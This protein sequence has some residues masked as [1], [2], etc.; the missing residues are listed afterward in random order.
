MSDLKE[1]KVVEQEKNNRE[2]GSLLDRSGEKSQYWLDKQAQ[3]EQRGK[4]KERKE[5]EKV[6]SA[7]ITAQTF[8]RGMLQM[9]SAMEKLAQELRANQLRL[10]ATMRLL[11]DKNLMTPLDTEK[12]VRDQIEWNRFIDSLATSQP[13]VPIHGLVAQIN[14]WNNTHDL[15]IVWQHV[16]LGVR[17][18]EE[19]GMTLEEKLMVAADM[20]MPEAFIQALR[21]KELGTEDPAASAIELA[22]AINAKA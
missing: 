10:E 18:L 14:E 1:V 2:G 16:D 9:Y 4:D 17:L 21:E 7:P 22:K 6:L 13:P 11:Y 15:K 5:A 19:E 3:K 20:D 12:Y 8:Q